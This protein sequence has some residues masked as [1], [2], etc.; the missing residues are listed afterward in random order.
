MTNN[1]NVYANFV[2]PGK[3]ENYFYSHSTQCTNLRYRIFRNHFWGMVS[4]QNSANRN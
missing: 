1:E 4:A 2:Y 3:I